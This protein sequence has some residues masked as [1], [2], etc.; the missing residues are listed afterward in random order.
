M[1]EIEKL[2]SIMADLR[3]PEKGCPWDIKQDYKSVLPYTLEEAYEVADAIESGD[4]QE[5]KVELGDLLFQIVF[6]AQMAKEDGLFEFRDIVNAINQKLISRHPHV[7]ADVDCRDE[8]LLHEAWEASKAAERNRKSEQSLSALSGVAAA[9]PALKRSQ[10]LQKRAAR[11]GFDW[12]DIQ[13]V[14]NKINEEINELQEA[15]EEKDSAHIE[16]EMG[17]ILFACVNLSRHLNMDAEEALRKSNQK[18][19]K[20]FACIEKK[21]SQTNK[22]MEDC[23]LD[24]L[25]AL[26]HEAKQIL[27]KN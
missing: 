20:R 11:K 13:P 15:I 5:L 16:E 8:K 12:P 21:L 25:E 26:W 19:I 2:L 17:D 18:F 23:S 9:L 27:Q 7:F 4:M 6:Y 22:A 3:E 1:Q 14:F 10:K 24:E